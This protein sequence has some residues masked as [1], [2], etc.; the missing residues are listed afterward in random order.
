[1]GWQCW[2]RRCAANF[3]ALRVRR[4]NGIE[5][6]SPFSEI[7][8]SPKLIRL[9]R[10]RCHLHHLLKYLAVATG[11][12]TRPYSNAARQLF[13]NV[14]RKAADYSPFRVSDAERRRQVDDFRTAGRKRGLVGIFFSSRQSRSRGALQAPQLLSSQSDVRTIRYLGH[15]VAK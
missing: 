3:V 15:R 8:G 9:P 10:P 2:K 6:A 11:R 5:S 4:S 13:R 14:S 12:P 1:M 7:A